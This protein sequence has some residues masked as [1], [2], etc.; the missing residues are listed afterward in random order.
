VKLSGDVMKRLSVSKQTQQKSDIE[1]FHFKK[2]NNVEVKEQYLK[3]S[4]ITATLEN[5][6]DNVNNNRD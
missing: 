6:N 3:I 5:L 1:G 4:N 2:L